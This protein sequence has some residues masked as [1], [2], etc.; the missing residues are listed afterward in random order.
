MNMFTIG[1]ILWIGWFIIEEGWAIY[2]GN[3]K[4]TLSEHVFVWFGVKSPNSD[5]PIKLTP[6]VRVRRVIL[7][8]F[9]AW[10][11]VHFLT[12]GEF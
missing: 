5:V 1:W 3:M 9:M 11:T 2:T 10:L 7:L 4:N 8:A 12:G 6:W